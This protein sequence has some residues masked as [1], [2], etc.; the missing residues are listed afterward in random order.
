MVIWNSLISCYR[1][2]SRIRTPSI[3][4]MEWFW[5]KT[6]MVLAQKLEVC[7]SCHELHFFCEICK[8]IFGYSV[9]KLISITLTVHALHLECVWVFIWRFWPMIWRNASFMLKMEMMRFVNMILFWAW[10]QVFMMILTPSKHH[11]WCVWS[12]V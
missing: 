7:I 5:S 8:V 10:Y 6:W 4:C 12:V 9:S 11:F 1:S 2:G 3:C